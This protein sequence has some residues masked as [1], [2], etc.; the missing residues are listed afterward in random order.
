MKTFKIFFLVILIF[1]LSVYAQNEIPKAIWP[2]KKIIVDGDIS[3]WKQPLSFY[4]LETGEVYS[5][6]NDSSSLYLCFISN[7]AMKIRKLIMGGWRINLSSKEKDNKFNCSLVFHP[8][9]ISNEESR[10][11][12]GDRRRGPSNQN[13]MAKAYKSELTS[14]KAKGFKTMNGKLPLVNENGIN[15]CVGSDSIRKLCYEIAIP[16]K[17]LMAENSIQLN[18][19]I[20]L[21]VKVNSLSAPTSGGPGGGGGRSGGGGYGGGSGSR[22]G[23]GYGGGSRGGG[24]SGSYGGGQGR[25]S[26]SVDFGDLYVTSK[27]KQ[28][29]VLRGN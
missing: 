19:Q 12:G 2:L 29:F 5:V 20:T 1:R 15:I 18:E 16:L 23:G 4:S 6:C 24:G 21:D 22:G 10:S 8:V 14:I 28:T 13:M 11:A 25:G 26:G 9:T 27:S 7:D 3:E 17:E